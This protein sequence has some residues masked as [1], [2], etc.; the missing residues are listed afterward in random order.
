MLEGEILF[1]VDGEE[2]RAAAGADGRNPP[3][4]ARMRSSIV[5]DTARFLVLNT[6]GGHDRFF[7]AGGVA[8]TSRDFAAAPPPDHARTMAAAAAHGVVFLGPPPF[9]AS[10]VRVASG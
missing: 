8:A 4:R 9:A 3:R 7:R 1:H 10:S 2:Q 5:S 6:P